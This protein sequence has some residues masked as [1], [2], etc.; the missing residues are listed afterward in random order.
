MAELQAGNCAPASVDNLLYAGLFPPIYDRPI[1]PS[2]W[3]QDYVGT[4][5]ERDVRQI[6]NIQDLATFQRF[7]QLCAG[8]IGQLVNLS[9]L[10]SDAGISRITADSWLSVLQ[11]SHL[12]FLARTACC[13]ADLQGEAHSA[14]AK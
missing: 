10:A 8:C 13:L 3:I 14:E 11:A 5:L 7:I 6:L 12:I 2:I 1:E 9:S 4:Y